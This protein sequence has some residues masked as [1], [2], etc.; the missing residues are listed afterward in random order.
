MHSWLDNQRR[1]RKG[2]QP[3]PEC[4]MEGEGEKHRTYNKCSL[5]IPVRGNALYAQSCQQWPLKV[6]FAHLEHELNSLTLPKIAWHLL[7]QGSVTKCSQVTE[8]RTQST[9][10]GEKQEAGGRVR[11]LKVLQESAPSGPCDTSEPPTP[12]LVPQPPPRLFILDVF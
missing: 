10:R 6:E 5:H 7:L 9:L 8:R 4:T 12:Y 3:S 2:W 11:S 1:G